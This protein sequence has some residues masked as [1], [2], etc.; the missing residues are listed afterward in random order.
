MIVSL[1]NSSEWIYS[2]VEELCSQSFYTLLYFYPKDNTPWCT[3]E[4]KE[5][6]RLKHEFEL[7]KC[8]I[9]GVSKDTQKSHCLFIDKQGLEFWLI[10][11]TSLELHKDLRFQVWVGKSMYGKKYMGTRRSSFLLNNKAE[12]IAFWYD[13]KPAIHPTQVLSVLQA[14]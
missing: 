7:I 4:A 13:V 3:L 14:L 5:F 10:S 9:V 2:S 6:N 11:D 12:V 1:P 8:Q